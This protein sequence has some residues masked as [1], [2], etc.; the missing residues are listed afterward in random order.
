M[1]VKAR[2]VSSEDA[3]I[4]SVRPAIATDRPNLI[5]LLRRSWLTSF[6]AYLPFDAVQTFATEDPARQYVDT[7]WGDFA[8]A[9]VDGT[10]IGMVHVIG[11]LVAAIHV[12]P[13]SKRRGIGAALMDRAESTIFA[14]HMRARLEVLAFNTAAQAFYRRRGWF[15]A[16]CYPTQEC[17]VPVEAIEMVKAP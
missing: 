8:V 3:T 16:R 17:G 10:A 14:S 1:D 13:N 15:K 4:L 2:P 7:M 11:D 5:T 9:D 6:A 12:D